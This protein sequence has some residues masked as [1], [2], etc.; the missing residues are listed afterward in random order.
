MLYPNTSIYPF[1][2]DDLQTLVDYAGGANIVYLGRARPGTAKS[3]VGWQIR[4][5]TYDGGNV[6]ITQFADGDNDYSK[7]WSDRATYAYGITT[8]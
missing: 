7:M 8:I 3:D 4:K 5:F 1:T 6:I 2:R